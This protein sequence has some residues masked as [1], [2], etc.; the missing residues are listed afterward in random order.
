MG[1]YRL[2]YRKRTPHPVRIRWQYVGVL[3][4]LLILG[5]WCLRLSASHFGATNVK[6]A[7]SAAASRPGTTESLSEMRD[8]RTLRAVYPYSVIPGGIRSARELQSDISADPVVRA[9]YAGFDMS[10]AHMIRLQQAKLVYVSYRIGNDVYWTKHRLKLAKNEAVITD[11]THTARSR[12]GNRVSDTRVLPTSPK[13][14]AVLAMDTAVDTAA[15]PELVVPGGPNPPAG[16]HPL[17]AAQPP[18]DGEPFIPLVL[19]LPPGGGAGG[20]GGGTGGH[21]RLGDPKVG[22][23]S[24]NPPGVPPTAVPEPDTLPLLLI[25]LPL[26]WMLGKRMKRSRR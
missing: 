11:G 21:K 4:L 18:P 1:I 3:I 14:P 2:Q 19:M 16:A 5:I 13:E 10:K 24:G 17:V 25:S 23:P 26:L 6:P 9:H 20:S 8:V 7:A 12:C 22:D 15:L